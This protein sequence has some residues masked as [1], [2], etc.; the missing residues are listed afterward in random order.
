MPRPYWQ[1]LWLLAACGD[2]GSTFCGD[3]PCNGPPGLPCRCGIASAG[4]A[5][6]SQDA[7]LPTTGLQLTNTSRDSV[8]ELKVGD[9]VVLTLQTIGPGDY[10]KPEL[11]SAA[12]SF[13]GTS[14]VSPPNP[15]GPQRSYVFHAVAAGEATL[16]I[17]HSVGATFRLTF[18]VQ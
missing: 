7:Q 6:P 15:G 10:G 13:D 14:L 8:I 1:L 9:N 3:S 16:T 11:S 17:P 5:A 12:V 4:S 18:H 2:A